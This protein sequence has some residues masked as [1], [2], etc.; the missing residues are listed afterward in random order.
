MWTSLL[1]AYSVAEVRRSSKY[2]TEEQFQT[3]YRTKVGQ[4]LIK[5]CSAQGNESHVINFPLVV[6]AF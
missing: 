3:P 2:L 5:I 4:L 1:L 6:Y